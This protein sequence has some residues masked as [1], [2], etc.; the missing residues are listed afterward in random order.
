[1]PVSVVLPITDRLSKTEMIRLFAG[2]EGLPLLAC[3]LLY[4]DGLRISECLRLRIKDLDFDYRQLWVRSGKGNKD[5]ATMIPEKAISKLKAQAK[6]V[7][8]LHKKTQ[9]LPSPQL[10]NSYS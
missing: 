6:K 5:R 3:E 4:G 10:R 2:L 1:M 9:T 8:I 7:Q